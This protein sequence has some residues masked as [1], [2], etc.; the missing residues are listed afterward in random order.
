MS[1]KTLPANQARIKK[2]KELMLEQ[3]KKNPIVQVACEK[4]QVPRATH[5]RWC[6]EDKEYAQ[7]VELAVIEGIALCNDYTEST[8]LSAIQSGDIGA[9]KFWLRSNHPRYRNKIEV[10]G[11]FTTTELTPEQQALIE[12]ALSFTRFSQD[13]LGEQSPLESSN[14][15]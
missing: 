13:N 1:A 3:L 6:K 7:R 10:T 12:K 2:Q 11:N 9:A 4:T 5:Y 14:N 15:K 8:L